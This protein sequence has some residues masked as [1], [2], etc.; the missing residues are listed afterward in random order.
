MT[1]WL[2]LMSVRKPALARRDTRGLHEPTCG[3]GTL[4]DLGE[5]NDNVARVH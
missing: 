2:D 1:G 4:M 5:L 3:V